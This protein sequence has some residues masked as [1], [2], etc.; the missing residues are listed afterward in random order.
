MTTRVVMEM[1]DHDVGSSS[2]LTLSVEQLPVLV[3]V[4]EE[5]AVD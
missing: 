3:E 5:Q 2:L 4:C 1:C